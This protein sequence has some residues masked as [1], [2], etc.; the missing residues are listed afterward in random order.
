MQ[1]CFVHLGKSVIDLYLFFFY[2][3]L[4]AVEDPTL[5]EMAEYM[6]VNRLQ[7]ICCGLII[8]FIFGLNFFLF[9]FWV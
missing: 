6:E 9:C 1:K 7:N 8:L 2:H 4:V 3:F 5:Q